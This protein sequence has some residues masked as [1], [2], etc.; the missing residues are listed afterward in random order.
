MR[1]TVRHQPDVLALR[2]VADVVG[3][4]GLRLDAEQRGVAA[5]DLARS[6]TGCRTVLIPCVVE[7][8]MVVVPAW[9]V[10]SMT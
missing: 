9:S 5:L 1:S 7:V 6:V 4:V 10:M 2:V 8:V 3:R